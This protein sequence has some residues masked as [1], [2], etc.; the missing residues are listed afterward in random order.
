[1]EAGF[2][3][4]EAPLSTSRGLQSTASFYARIKGSPIHSS[5]NGKKKPVCVYCKAGIFLGGG[6]GG[7]LPPLKMVLPPPELCLKW[8]NDKINFI[9]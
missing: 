7:I 3:T 2:Y 1:M 9:I 6:K 5:H 4:S 8:L